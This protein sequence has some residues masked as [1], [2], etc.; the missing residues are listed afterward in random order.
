MELFEAFQFNYLFIRWLCKWLCLL[1][2]SDIWTRSSWHD[3]AKQRDDVGCTWCHRT[4]NIQ[5]LYAILAFLFYAS[6]YVSLFS[7]VLCYA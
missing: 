2:E 4:T 5:G 6:H 1:S 3:T 7:A